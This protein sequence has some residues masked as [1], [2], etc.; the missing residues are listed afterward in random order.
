MGQSETKIKQPEKVVKKQTSQTKHTEKTKKKIQSKKK[1]QV[2]ETPQL[3]YPAV[4]RFPKKNQTNEKEEIFVKGSFSDWKPLKM[5]RSEED[6]SLIMNL[7]QGEHEFQFVTKDDEPLIDPNG[8][9]IEKNDQLYQVLNVKEPESMLLSSSDLGSVLSPNETSS[10]ETKKIES[11]S[12][13]NED[14]DEGYSQKFPTYLS[15]SKKPPKI[16]PQLRHPPKALESS[17]DSSLLA[18]PSHVVLSH[19]YT[20]TRD[21]VAIYSCTNRYKKKYYTI[22]LYKPLGN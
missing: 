14:E 12:K 6:F 3:L 5:N 20:I 19:L 11:K 18:V 8:E 7:P 16:P 1:K 10:G 15:Y 4:F 17:L 21:D 9:V 2:K 22:V 13:I